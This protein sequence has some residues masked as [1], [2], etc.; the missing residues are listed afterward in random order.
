MQIILANGMG[1]NPIMVTGAIQ[2][3]QN[4]NR[5]ALTFVFDETASLTE[6]DAIFTPENCETITIVEKDGEA[7]HKGYTIRAE[8]VKKPVTAENETPVAE[9]TTVTRVFVTMAQRTYA[10]SKLA[11][12]ASESTDTQIAVA[13]LAEIIMG[14]M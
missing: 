8:L 10:E 14:G 13:E 2:F 12:L 4:A 5:D 3:V 6:L 1:V 9:E 11:K 7:I